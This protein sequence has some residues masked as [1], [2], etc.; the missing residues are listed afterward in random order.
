MRDRSERAEHGDPLDRQQPGG[1]RPSQATPKSAQAC[2]CGSGLPN[3]ECHGVREVD[4]LVAAPAD[5]H[6]RPQVSARGRLLA[7][8]PHSFSSGVATRCHA[9]GAVLTVGL[10]FGE[11]DVVLV[12]D[13]GARSQ[14]PRSAHATVPPAT[15]P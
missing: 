12:C 8:D 15:D 2:P 10:G 9:C 13:C 11:E 6:R 1:L 14:G 7:S 3:D 4:Y 5:A